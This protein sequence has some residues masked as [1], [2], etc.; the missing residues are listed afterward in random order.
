MRNKCGE[1]RRRLGVEWWEEEEEK[2]EE[3][4]WER[5]RCELMME[6][7]GRWR[8]YTIE[9][10]LEE[11]WESESTRIRRPPSVVLTAPQF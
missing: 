9:R 4:G 7:G 2:C 1:V 11:E 5:G 6:W 8:E 10:E 3:W